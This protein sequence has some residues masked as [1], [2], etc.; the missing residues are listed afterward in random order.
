MDT[1]VKSSA[2][3]T[4]YILLGIIAMLLAGNAY[5]FL[6]QDNAENSLVTIREE[7]AFLR[8]ELNE[9]KTE[10]EKVSSLNLDLSRELRERRAELQ[11]KIARLQ[12]ALQNN[13]LT[14]KQLQKTKS[15]VAGLR[16]YVGAYLAEIGALKKQKS[17]LI[18]ENQHLR[19]RVDAEQQRNKEL[20]TKNLELSEKISE[21]AV[22]EAEKVNIVTFYSRMDRGRE[23][24]DQTSRASR[25]NKIRIEFAFFPNQVAEEGE[26]EICFRILDPEGNLLKSLDNDDPS[27]KDVNGAT[28]NCTGSSTI[29][30]ARSSPVY[31]V[32]MLR[33]N[34]L[35]KGNYQ[36]QLFT[37][38]RQIGEGKFSLK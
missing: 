5:L 27:F 19:T 22:L 1:G 4:I 35:A 17:K 25:V 10:L 11:Q 13:Q 31:A 21:A 20:A 29:F 32:E 16:N 38:G 28:V 34:D 9:L 7:K 36:V 23:Y 8:Q 2:S 33:E 14:A 6:T 18:A 3:A 26:R 15:E 12:E 24:E 30:Y 37:G